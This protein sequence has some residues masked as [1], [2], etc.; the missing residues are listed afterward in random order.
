MNHLPGPS[1]P[2]SLDRRA[3]LVLLG[4]ALVLLFAVAPLGRAGLWDPYELGPADFA[5]RIAHA[6]MG[7][8]GVVVPGAD[9]TVPHLNDL[10]RGQA[11]DTWVAVGFR[12]FGLHPESGRAMLALSGLFAVLVQG[13]G[14]ARVFGRKAGVYAGVILAC[15][16]PFALGSRLLL[17]DGLA[18]QMFA[19]SFATGLVLYCAPKLSRA[20]NLAWGL[21]F[22][23]SL[24]VGFA[25]RGAHVVV[26]V[27]GALVLAHGARSEATTRTQALLSVCGAITGTVLALAIRDAIL[28]PHNV[29]PWLGM[30]VRP[31][32]HAPTFDL[33]LGRIAH[34]A[35]PWSALA[36][37]AAAA[38]L[39]ASANPN[40]AQA[41]D[42]TRARL[43]RARRAVLLSAVLAF[44]AAVADGFLRD[45]GLGYLAWG[46]LAIACALALSDLDVV[47]ERPFGLALSGV[48]IAALVHHDFHGLPDKAAEAFG[49]I[50]AKLPA[51][52]APATYTY[53][54][55]VLFSFAAALLLAALPTPAAPCAQGVHGARLHR[56]SAS[57]LLGVYQAWR[58]AWG[59]MLAAVHLLIA[60]AFAVAAAVVPVLALLHLAVPTPMHT[61]LQLLALGVGVLV[62]P[63]AA[64]GGGLVLV[65]L[66]AWAFDPSDEV[67]TPGHLRGIR[68]VEA[69]FA[70]CRTGTLVERVVTGLVVLPVL[71]LVT[72]LLSYAALHYALE[73]KPAYAALLAAPTGVLLVVGLGWLA[74]ATAARGAPLLL[75]GVAGALLLSGSYYPA[76]ADAVSPRDI[77]VEYSK[78]SDKGSFAVFGISSS[79]AAYYLPQAPTVLTSNDEA[80]GWISARGA[81]PWFLGVKVDDLPRLNQA[82]RKFTAPQAKNLP[83]LRGGTK[84]T[85]LASNTGTAQPGEGNPLNAVVLSEKPNPSHMLN[86][87]LEGGLDVLGYD[88]VDAA[89]AKVE[90]FASGSTVRVRVYY[91]V[92]TAPAAEWERFVHVDGKGQH[93]TADGKLAGGKYPSNLWLPGDYIVDAFDFKLDALPAGT[94]EFYLGLWQ[95]SNEK[96]AKVVSGPSDGD[97][98]IRGGA[99]VIK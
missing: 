82:Y 86:V 20:E 61:S 31:P 1:R 50:N 51:S 17:G 21:L 15:M 45:G 73:M 71:L 70:D 9:N 48:V 47:A 54:T 22:A 14:V 69:A 10:A 34:G 18:L 23:S 64:A 41:A 75:V 76:L 44:G 88:Y 89:G 29:S 65:D 63:F 91:A 38:L 74:H 19:A 81:S 90:S 72:P 27:L 84:S 6:L 42:P 78:S 13:A 95:P 7:A 30:L 62:A 3:W 97:N 53:F 67:T 2:L 32:A 16:A 68:L 12:F 98:R 25:C 99:L 52:F 5:R 80:S 94:Y 66:W 33:V 77:F 4:V 55:V 8:N 40:T 36:P 58:S 39:T 85:L 11:Q 43:A 56:P 35:A 37:L 26:P 28:A 60:G 96:R 46:P 93:Q 87:E 83:V 57:R 24:C 79:T 92:K 49:L 59:G